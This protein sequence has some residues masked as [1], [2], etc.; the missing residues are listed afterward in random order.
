[1]WKK[2]NFCIDLR[3]AN[4]MS[5]MN[6]NMCVFYIQTQ[7]VW[8]NWKLHHA[9]N[10]LKLRRSLIISAKWTDV[11]GTHSA[12]PRSS[13]RSSFTNT[14]VRSSRKWLSQTFPFESSHPPNCDPSRYG[15]YG[16]VNKMLHFS[17]G[18]RATFQT[19]LDV[20]W[21]RNLNS[22]HFLEC[23]LTYKK[24]NSDIEF[25]AGDLDTDFQ[26]LRYIQ[27]KEILMVC[28]YNENP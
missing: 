6:N 15:T 4:D 9:H 28:P 13:F 2:R 25:H 12:V 22:E 21:L 27:R 10:S 11:S 8:E 23:T 24:P 3:S 16:L 5:L 18:S 19:V 20:I 26:V 7:S 17:Y 14:C 1:M